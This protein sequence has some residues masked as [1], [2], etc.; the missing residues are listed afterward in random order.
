M[1]ARHE[2]LRT[3]FPVGPD[4]EPV[5]RIAANSPFALEIADLRNLPVDV[6][7]ERAWQF[8][9]ATVGCRFDLEQGP[10]VRALLV[11]IS[12]DEH[13]M[14]LVLHELVADRRSVE[15]LTDELATLY[16]AHTGSGPSVLPELSSQFADFALGQRNGDGATRPSLSYWKRNLAGNLPVLELPTDQPRSPGRSFLSPRNDSNSRPSLTAALAHRGASQGATLFVTLLA[17]FK[18]LLWRYTGQTDMIVG[19]P[20]SGRNSSS[21]A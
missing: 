3:T 10:L 20:V 18:A 12:D 15:I 17:A 6:R 4:G 14:L 7:E 19:S 1:I 9:G 5:Q 13:L 11:Q 8:I 2:I 21:T 16:A